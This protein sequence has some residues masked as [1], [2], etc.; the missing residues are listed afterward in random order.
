MVEPTSYD[1]HADAIVAGVLGSPEGMALVRGDGRIVSANAALC[2]L[3]GMDAEALRRTAIADIAHER[4]R[5]VLAAALARVVAGEQHDLVADLRFAKPDGTTVWV[6]FTCVPVQSAATIEPLVYVQLQDISDRKD[7]EARLVHRATHDQLTGLPSRA[8]FLEQLQHALARLCRRSD[9]YVAVLFI[10]LDG[11][12]AVNDTHGHAIGDELLLGVASRL[13]R[14]LRPSDVVARLGGDEFTVLLEDIRHPGEAVAVAERMLEELGPPFPLSA[15]LIDG[16]A[17]IGI[18]VGTD[19]E[20]RPDALLANADAAMYRAKQRGGGGYEVFDEESFDTL[21]QRRRLETDLRHTLRD[22]GFRL[23]YQPIIDLR[24]G[25][26]AAAEALLRWEHPSLGVL[27]AAS[28][29]EVAE[30]SGLIIPI[31]R[32]VL[33]EACR[34]LAEWDRQ[35]GRRA[36]E[37]IFVNVG[38]RELVHDFAPGVAEV[39]AATGVSPHRLCIEVTETEILADPDAARSAIE[40]L[41]ALGCH[42]VVDDFGTG[43]SSL[44]RLTELHVDALKV[45]MSFVRTMAT[46]RESLAIVSAILLLAHNLRLEVVA[47]GIENADQLAVLHE[48]G[49]QY[50][51]GYHVARPADARE[52]AAIACGTTTRPLSVVS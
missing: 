47:E 1:E 31:G 49:C 45:D 39:L 41:S 11:L 52:F 37:R 19:G 34:Q 35:L 28:F 2:A 8:V 10:D 50:G 29:I 32:W 9:S 30:R 12:K 15:G 43:Y 48:M 17:S 7:A 13:R 38:G 14:A 40:A 44:S 6:T 25:R 18:A 22:G 24:S 3:V 51:Q 33:A 26:L 46:S 20:M 21:A 5:G 4:D 23:A 42:I 16:G 36:P 27:T